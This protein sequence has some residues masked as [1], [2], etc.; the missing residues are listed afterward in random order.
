MPSIST[1]I[2]KEMFTQMQGATCRNMHRNAICNSSKKENNL[3]AQI[4]IK[5]RK[6]NVI[7]IQRK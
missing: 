4:L 5:V 6:D 1:G 7:L 3:R 2:Y